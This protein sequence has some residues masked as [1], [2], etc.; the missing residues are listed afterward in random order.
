MA[1]SQPQMLQVPPNE[2]YIVPGGTLL[3]H[4]NRDARHAYLYVVNNH[5]LD[6]RSTP[7][8]GR[9]IVFIQ[10]TSENGIKNIKAFEAE[11]KVPLGPDRN[12][13]PL[14]RFLSSLLQVPVSF[15][16]IQESLS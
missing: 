6:Q 4:P 11:L 3:Y 2:Q 7:F 14:G 15:S 5:P 10:D 8:K 13:E 9:T 12:V 16:I 1:D